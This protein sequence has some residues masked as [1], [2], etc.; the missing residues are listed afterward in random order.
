MTKTKH[1]S[2]FVSRK[3]NISNTDKGGQHT[4]LLRY[5]WLANAEQNENKPSQIKSLK[6]GNFVI[7]LPDFKSTLADG[8]N[9]EFRVLK[10]LLDDIVVY[11]LFKAWKLD[12]HFHV[13]YEKIFLDF[14][15]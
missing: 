6:S 4:W 12:N 7:L 13:F 2:D 5:I 9:G 10:K 14:K 15:L 1:V 8:G 3:Y 11:F